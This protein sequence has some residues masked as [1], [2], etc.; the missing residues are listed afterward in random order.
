MVLSINDAADVENRRYLIGSYSISMF[1]INY[2]TTF[3]AFLKEGAFLKNYQITEFCH[4]FLAQHVQPGDFCIDATAGKGN[5]TEFLC[6]LV[7]SQG[8]VL[9][10]DI[11]QAAI[12]ATN[13]RLFTKG[14]A[15]IGNAILESHTNMHLYAEKGTVDCITFNFGYLPGGDHNL[16]THANTSISAIQTGLSLLK[17]QGLMSLCIYSGGDTGFE[18]RDA[19]LHYL[20][21]LDPKQYMVLL[22][23]YY[24]RPNNP[25]IPVFVLKLF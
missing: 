25:P 3:T 6:Q 5:D 14:L 2:K 17:K 20:K 21:Q 16:C 24:N 22:S 11:Q 18:E 1:V 23:C 4:H 7:G 13:E 19:I 9:A 15:D 10:F 12:D 8:R